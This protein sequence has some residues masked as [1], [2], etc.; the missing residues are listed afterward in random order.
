MSK[1]KYCKRM[2]ASSYQNL[3]QE[4]ATRLVKLRQE[5]RLSQK[6]LVNQLNSAFK[7]HA[8]CNISESTY[9]R[10]ESAE[11]FLSD[12]FIYAICAFYN[13][14]FDYLLCGETDV[15]NHF[16]DSLNPKAAKELCELLE[17]NLASLKVKF[18]F[19]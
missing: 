16:L 2:E 12:D 17:K 18:D 15:N 3:M 14:S 1:T 13:I 8:H 5:H 7:P 9:A 6:E 4:R 10:Y 11:V 19:N